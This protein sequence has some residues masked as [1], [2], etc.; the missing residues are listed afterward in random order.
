MTTNPNHRPTESEIEAAR[1][2]P[3]EHSPVHG[4]YVDKRLQHNRWVVPA[5]LYGRPTRARSCEPS[6]PVD[7]T[8]AENGEPTTAMWH[9][10]DDRFVVFDPVRPQLPSRAEVAREL[11]RAL[12]DPGSIVGYRDWDADERVIDWQARA[13]LALF[14]HLVAPDH[15]P[16][17]PT[18]ARRPETIRTTDTTGDRL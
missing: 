2:C 7:S 15:T 13:V 17:R 14:P 12:G 6:R 3:L 8:V 11:A 16:T 1:R 4:S 18:P 10:P 5:D 9:N